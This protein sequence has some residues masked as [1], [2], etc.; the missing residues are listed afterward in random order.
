M[1]SGRLICKI[2][3]A[4]NSAALFASEFGHKTFMVANIVSYC[5]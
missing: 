1:Q 3:F 2:L 5:A 4:K